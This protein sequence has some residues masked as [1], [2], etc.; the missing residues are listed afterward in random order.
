MLESL[1]GSSSSVPIMVTEGARFVLE[2][3]TFTVRAIVAIRSSTPAA[4]NLASAS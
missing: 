3:E 2:V 1:G 4:D